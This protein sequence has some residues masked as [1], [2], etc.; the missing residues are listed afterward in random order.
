[1][2]KLT[3]IITTVLVGG[4]VAQGPVGW[5]CDT[6]DR[7][8][9]TFVMAIIAQSL[10]PQLAGTGFGIAT[11]WQYVGITVAAPLIGYFFQTPQSL[12]LTFLSMSVFAFAS[13]V[14]AFTVRAK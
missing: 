8:K 3:V 7:R 2:K 6:F 12:P 5:L 10:S 1:M 14:I 11:L 4:L 13:A 9:I